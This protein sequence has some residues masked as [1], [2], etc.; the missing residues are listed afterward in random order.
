M[1]IGNY[2]ATFAIYNALRDS[3]AR[4]QTD[5]MRLQTEVVT[6]KLA[7]A[8]LV[9]G[10][11]SEQL[12]SFKSG[13]A[14]IDRIKDTNSVVLSR[15]EMTQ[16]SLANLG[17]AADDLVQTLGLS[18]GD[19]GQRGVVSDGADTA[20]SQI[21]A[22]L[23]VQ[24]DGAY[25]FGGINAG[26]APFAA[27]AGG[28]GQAAFDAAFSAFFGFAKTDPAAASIGA[29]DMTAFLE[30]VVEPDF[31]GAGWTAGYSS[32]T[33]DVVSARIA[34]GVV[35]EASV[36]ANEGAVRR[37]AMAAIVTREMHSGAFGGEGLEAAAAFA[38]ASARQAGAELAELSG[39]TGLIEARVARQNE[40]LTTQ[41]DVL[42]GLANDLEAVDRYDASTRLTTL[43]TQ[44][45]ASYATTAR[46]QQMSLLR[47]L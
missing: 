41:R 9:L 36:S 44:V 32:A 5:L 2:N 13:V 25:V 21:E 39:R 16:L 46:I 15:L 12:V 17:T 24:L 20:L 31:M 35:T 33:D 19:E 38:L 40:A 29:A 10:G 3:T 14:E 27:H 18:I 28:A 7:D 26:E 11:R 23:N 47:Y 30:T 34:A 4:M 6:G 45:E 37:I 42:T 8:G 43:L 22:A 1:Q